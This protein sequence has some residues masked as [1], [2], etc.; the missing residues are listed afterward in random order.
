MMIFRSPRWKLRRT[1]LK[2]CPKR[3]LR[4]S[5]PRLP[6]SSATINS[7]LD[8]QQILKYLTVNI[9][10][11][12]GMKGAAIRLLDEDS[13][14]LKL[15]ASH[16]L[17]E[18]LLDLGRHTGTETSAAALKGETLIIEDVA[19]DE[20]VRY[21]EELAAEGRH[22]IVSSHILHEVDVISDGV[23]MIHGGAIVAEGGI[24]EVRGEITSHPIQVLIR[25]DRPHAVAPASA[26]SRT[27]LT[28]P[29]PPRGEGILRNSLPRLREVYGTAC[30]GRR[31]VHRCSGSPNRNSLS[32]E[33]R[34]LG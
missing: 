2:R 11:T 19:T 5:R 22:V 3:G 24:R 25:C 14:S 26:G 1:R 29:S 30:K 8:I 13:G 4:R 6:Y 7:S 20:R 31:D 34:G 33:G 15:V 23:I 27:P 21:K 32:L 9:C 12:L 10:D 18:G 16:G 17:S 28:L